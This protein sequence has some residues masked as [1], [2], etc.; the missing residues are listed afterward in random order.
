M[1]LSVVF[2]GQLNLIFKNILEVEL[3]LELWR[4]YKAAFFEGSLVF[5]PNRVKVSTYYTSCSEWQHFL[6][7]HSNSA[8]VTDIKIKILLILK[9]LRPSR[10]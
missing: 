3:Q 5:Y 7:V 1:N 6:K 2:S 9:Y 4:C 8:I 10:K